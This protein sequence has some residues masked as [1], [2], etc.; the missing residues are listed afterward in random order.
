MV[1]LEELDKSKVFELIR[2]QTNRKKFVITPI[3]IL[4]NFGFPVA[5]HKFLLENKSTI[6]KL[7]LILF[8]LNEEGFLIERASKQ[9]FKGIKDK[10]YD[11]VT[12][13]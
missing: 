4:K 9:D 12:K 10:G 1:N 2:L 3:S 7:K 6:S 13:K 5:E 11:Y 8:E